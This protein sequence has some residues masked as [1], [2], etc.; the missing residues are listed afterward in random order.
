MAGALLNLA[1]VAFFIL[2]FTVYLGYAENPDLKVIRAAC[3]TT[4]IPEFC[5]EMLSGDPNN[6]GKDL[7]GLAAVAVNLA[8]V[9]GISIRI[10][11]ANLQKK[12]TDPVL[13]HILDGCFGDYDTG[14]IYDTREAIDEFGKTDYRGSVLSMSGAAS[15]VNQCNDSFATGSQENPLKDYNIYMINYLTV[16]VGLV[17]NFIDD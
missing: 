15:A 4:A 2:F 3:E 5:F 13:K 16:G 12:T 1:S 17:N 10:Y 14:V 6:R 9:R 11:I 7:H 8:N